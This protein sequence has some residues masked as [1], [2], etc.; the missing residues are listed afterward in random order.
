MD[1]QPR[2]YK[3]I[4]EEEYGLL[5]DDLK[6]CYDEIIHSHIQ[7]HQM[8]LRSFRRSLLGTRGNF[9]EFH[10]RLLTAKE[11]LERASMSVQ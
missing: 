2:S 3:E 10:G 5:Q 1:Q 9:E 6:R 11:A 4:E 8:V 7:K